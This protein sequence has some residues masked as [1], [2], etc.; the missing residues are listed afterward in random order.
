[1]SEIP[2]CTTSK[3]LHVSVIVYSISLNMTV[4]MRNLSAKCL[5]KC[6]SWCGK[7]IFVSIFVRNILV[8]YSRPE[9]TVFKNHLEQ[10]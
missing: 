1:M 7:T 2:L 10:R 4:S 9:N 5:L 8:I 6:V 3:R